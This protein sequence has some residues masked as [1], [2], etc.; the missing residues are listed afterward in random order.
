MV[1]QD[2]APSGGAASTPGAGCRQKQGHH[3]FR[4]EPGRVEMVHVR[5]D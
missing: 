4:R 2:S 5:A 1:R 3:E